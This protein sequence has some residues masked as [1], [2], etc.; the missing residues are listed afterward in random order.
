MAEPPEAKM[1]VLGEADD[2][3]RATEAIRGGRKSPYDV[4][5]RLPS[6]S[7]GEKSPVI[8]IGPEP[9]PLGSVLRALHRAQQEKVEHAVCKGAPGWVAMRGVHRNR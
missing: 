2:H 5:G 9:G 7:L 8:G 3:A 6:H 1:T 4:V